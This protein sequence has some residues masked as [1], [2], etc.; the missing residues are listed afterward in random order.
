VRPFT[1]EQISQFVHGWCRA[2]ERL[3]T[4]ASGPEIDQ[5][6]FEE[7]E[8][9][10]GQLSSAPA[11]ME[12]AVNPLLL[13]MM[14]LV[15]RERRSLP[16]GRADLYSQ[17]CDVMLWRRLE[18]K[19]LEV[20]PPGAVRQ[21]I[22]AA[23]AYDM[24][25]AETR[26]YPK[27]QVLEIFDRALQQIGTD[28]GAEELLTALVETS[29]LLVE[30]EKDLYSFAHHTIG[31]YLASTH[32]RN[33]NLSATL[34][35]SV[36]DPWWRETTLLYVTDADANDIVEASL[37]ENTG[38]SL[39]LAFDCVRSQGQLDRQL[40]NWLDR[41]RQHAFEEDATP[42]QRRL[43]ARALASGHLS[44]L[45]TTGSGSLISSI[46]IPEDLYWLFC[47]DTGI[48][49][50]DGTDPHGPDPERPAAGIR[51]S[52]VEAFIAWVNGVSIQ[53]SPV[54]YRLPT[55]AEVEFVT[56]HS[57]LRSQDLPL[58]SAWTAMP[59]D[60]ADPGPWTADGSDPHT[61]L[62]A[63]VLR[64]AENDLVHTSLLFDFALA[65]ARLDARALDRFYDH[66]LTLDH[67]RT[68]DLNF[69]SAFLIANDL[70][71][72]ID[73]AC[74][75]AQE[76][77]RTFKL[78][79]GLDLRLMRKYALGLAFAEARFSDL[80]SFRKLAHG[81]DNAISSSIPFASEIEFPDPGYLPK[82]FSVVSARAAMR[83]KTMGSS[84]NWALSQAE[85]I[86]LTAKPGGGFVYIGE[87][88]TN[89]LFELSGVDEVRA[90]RVDLDS[91]MNTLRAACAA[92]GGQDIEL[93][94]H[95]WAASAAWRLV[96]IARPVFTRIQRPDLE[97]LANI[98]VAALLLAAEMQHGLNNGAASAFRSV[99]AGVTLL[100]RRLNGEAPL[101]TIL[102]ARE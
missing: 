26:D 24:M 25:V 12:L 14:V 73:L 3:A 101:E 88:L 67:N 36:S 51:R 6:A 85:S 28:I 100:E 94:K 43:V 76:P 71:R 34:I 89:W 7:A 95:S 57:S 63:D 60:G 37:K 90:E 74:N 53:E 96:R 40:R 56:S 82:G 49:L 99:A 4:G 16:A 2:A 58:E 79:R 8:D 33:K 9:L 64:A 92:V 59:E 21:R 15:H 54:F 83:E 75:L 44:K 29:G 48:P 23:L 91:L 102:L 62:G 30:R 65:G 41:F 97:D 86:G 20:K 61:I 77:S 35:R 38:T 55:T 52:D 1:T 27:T 46:S 69:K 13:T 50:P 32:I 17:V 39:A 11:L 10:I 66:A 42:S 47:K 80:A 81:I 72:G 98:R 22:L 5:R 87:S 19:K 68:Y 84:L 93:R 70:F 31:E 18:S 45:V 78:P